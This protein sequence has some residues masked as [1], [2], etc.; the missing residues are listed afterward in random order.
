MEMTQ[1]LRERF[2]A[3]DGAFYQ[4]NGKESHLILRKVQFSDGS[5]PSGNAVHCE[6]FA[7]PVRSHSGF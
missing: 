2:K 4:T 3:Q 6:E 5:E 1:I 7:A